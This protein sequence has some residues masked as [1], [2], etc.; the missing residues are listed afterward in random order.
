MGSLDI[1]T[2]ENPQP[3]PSGWEC[4]VTGEPFI[5]GMR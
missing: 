2:A 1:D 5:V 3:A 4:S